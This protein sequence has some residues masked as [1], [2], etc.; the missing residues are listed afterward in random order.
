MES[1]VSGYLPSHCVGGHIKV[2]NVEVFQHTEVELGLYQEGQRSEVNILV[3][4]R[5]CMYC[6]FI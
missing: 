4:F 6:P 5:T 1:R 3:D 2:T